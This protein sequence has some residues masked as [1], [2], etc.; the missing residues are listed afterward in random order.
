MFLKRLELVGFKSFATR[1][2]AEF[3]PR[4]GVIV[5]PNGSG[6]SNIAD[7]VRWVLGEQSARAVRA[8]RPEEV[9][10]AGSATRQP[11]GMSEVS[12]VLDNAEGVLPI[13]YGEVRV[14]RRLYRSGESEYLLNG[15]RVRLKDITQ[16]LLHAGLG[17]DAYSVIGQGSVDELILQRPEERRVAFESAADIRRHQLK[18]ADTRSRLAT[19]E[20]NLVRVQDVI[21]ELAPHVRRLRGQAERAS[22]AAGVRA[23]LHA[24]SLGWFRMRLRDARA[25]RAEAE[26]ELELATERVQ[27]AEADT[28]AAEQSLSADDRRMAALEA[29]QAD[30]RP[31]AELLRE[32]ARSAEQGLAVARERRAS[33]AEQQTSLQGEVERL[34]Q[35]VERLAAEDMGEV[36][37]PSG[38]DAATRGD[39]AAMGGTRAERAATDVAH[40][41][42]GAAG[43]N[44]A[45]LLGSDAAEAAALRARLEELSPALEVAQRARA[46][47]LLRRE[48]AEHR[49]RELETRLAGS[50][51][52][53]RALEAARAVEA[54]RAAD[55]GAR[56]TAL[57]ERLPRLS[58]DH[59]QARARLED[60][61]TALA[62]A[63]AARRASAEQVER[64]REAARIASQQA[65]RLQGALAALGAPSPQPPRRRGGDVPEEWRAVLEGIPVLGLAGEMAMRARPID[66]LLR[67]YLS[68]TLVV[69]DAK[70]ARQA[71]RRLSEALPPDAPAWAIL[72]LDG[73]LLGAPGERPV[74]QAAAGG[75]ALA[76]WRRRIEQAHT[77][78]TA[79]EQARATA[80]AALAAARAALDTAERDERAARVRIGE[81][82]AQAQQARRAESSAA[83]ELAQ[84]RAEHERTQ[85]PSSSK[86]TQAVELAEGTREQLEAAR[87]SRD[88]SLEQLRLAEGEAHALLDTVAEARTRLSALEA[89]EAQRQA[90]HKARLVLRERIRTELEA[91][92]QARQAAETRLAQHVQQTAELRERETRLLNELETTLRELA[93]IEEQ[94]AKDEHDRAE[95]VRHRRSIEERLTGL[96]AEERAARETREARLVRRQ[97]AKDDL[98]RVDQE[99]VDAA[100][101]SGEEPGQAAWIEQLR[102]DDTSL[103]PSRRI[104]NATE[105]CGRPSGATEPLDVDAARRRIGTLQRELR[106]VGSVGDTVVEE[107]RELTERHDFLVEQSQD[108]RTAMD[109]LQQAAEELEATMRDRFEGVF[110]ATGQ[111]FERCFIRLFGGGEARLQLTDPADPLRSGIDIVARPPGKKL[112][113]LLSLS[114]GERALT[115]VALLFGLLEVNPTPFCV[116]DEV[117][118]ALDD[119]NVQRFADLLVDFSRRIHFIVVT[120]NRATMDIADSLYGVSMDAQSISHLFSVQPQA[121]ARQVRGPRSAVRA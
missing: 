51:Q 101:L 60:A 111:A 46:E 97:R 23:E 8:R 110:A 41:A 36:A 63:G 2:V 56:I 49:I 42:M 45:P 90:E 69:P 31:R 15:S 62:Q 77:E 14:T 27:H 114:G 28:Q 65:D 80:E 35:Q 33:L 112:Q 58:A 37:E 29:E 72:S 95:L 88:L 17:P 5:G 113:N 106:V 10:F 98:E 87:A 47:A 100:E 116:L 79:A 25:A 3:T 118:A 92:R 119:S 22:R 109:E 11:L 108:L 4:I 24:L 12:L 68:R 38:A 7:A 96:R 53:L 86:A 103:E 91:A 19:T 57:E 6:K 20:A 61:R 1:T 81:L 18:L 71:H 76:D 94:L 121:L 55:H 26:R 120:H 78:L 73:L 99:I 115:I 50:E 13:E 16:Q 70:A 64:A 107:Y 52:Q 89:A 75:S 67:G 117:D 9:I 83:S 66:R 84:L 105:P 21:A 82:E 74:E 85:R 34:R 93:P 40:A 43:T 59:A 32:Q 48:R 54:A 102:Q 30:Q 104:D 39:Q 44:E